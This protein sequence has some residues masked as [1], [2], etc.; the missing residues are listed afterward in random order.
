MADAQEGG[1][2]ARD[3][4]DG[5]QDDQRG[6]EARRRHANEAF[7]LGARREDDGGRVVA[8]LFQRERQIARRHHLDDSVDADVLLLRRLLDAVDVALT[9]RRP[10]DA[11][12]L[13]ALAGRRADAGVRIPGLGA[14]AGRVLLHAFRSRALVGALVATDLNGALEVDLHGIGELERLFHIFQFEFF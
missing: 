12:L 10:L 5:Q 3:D 11:V 7:S 2:Q 4:Q 14:S 9:S 6:C 13:W 8:G 1:Q